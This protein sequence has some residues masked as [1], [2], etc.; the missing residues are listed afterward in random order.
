MVFISLNVLFG[1]LTPYFIVYK[2]Q[3][4]SEGLYTRSIQILLKHFATTNSE[5]IKSAI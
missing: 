2:K 4:I 3:S 1:R 5:H